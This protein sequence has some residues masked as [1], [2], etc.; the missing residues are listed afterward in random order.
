[1]EAAVK[2]VREGRFSVAVA[3]KDHGVPRS[4]LQFRLSPEYKKSSCG[5]NPILSIEEENIV[6]DWIKD[7]AKK[8][9]P[10]ASLDLCLSVQSF[11]KENPRPNPFVDDYPGK[12]WTQAFFRRHPDIVKRK[13][14]AVYQAS[15]C[16]SKN[17]LR[18]WFAN[19]E[20]V[21]TEENAFNILQDPTRVYNG[22]ETNFLL[23]ATTNMVLAAKGSR[24]VYNVDGGEAKAA[25]RQVRMRNTQFKLTR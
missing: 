16:V 23:C 6:C 14:E 3:A 15:A 18:G 4:T 21:L 7:C 12:G 17:D 9:F 2:T 19:I 8:G 24:N 13:C 22:D 10:K 25:M 1:M 5:P 20:T 11:L